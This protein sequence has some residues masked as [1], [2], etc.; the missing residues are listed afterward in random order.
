[1]GLRQYGNT[2][3]VMYY[4]YTADIAVLPNFPSLG[5]QTAYR[6]GFLPAY[7]P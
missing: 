6:G 1:M 2:A 5:F 4:P 3:A 7:P